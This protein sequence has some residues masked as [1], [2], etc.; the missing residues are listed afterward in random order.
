VWGGAKAFTVTSGPGFS[1]MMEHIGYA[2]ITET[3]CVF[4]NVQRGGP[5]TACRRCRRRPI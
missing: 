3:P 5:S 1:L 2:A 4:V